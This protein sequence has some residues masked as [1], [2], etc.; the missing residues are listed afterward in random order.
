MTIGLIPALLDKSKKIGPLKRFRFE[1]VLR[2]YEAPEPS[3]IIYEHLH[4]PLGIRARSVARG[5]GVAVAL[6]VAASAAVVGAA[7]AVGATVGIVL[8]MGC[9]VMLP[10]VMKLVSRVFEV[11]TSRSSEEMSV[12][13]KLVLARWTITGVLILFA[14][15]K[16]NLLEPFNLH[17]IQ[18]VLLADA[19]TNPIVKLCDFP[20]VLQ[21]YVFARRA[22]T[23]ARM[24]S[25]FLGTTV[26]WA[27][28][29]TDMT[30]TVFVALFYMPVFPLSVFYGAFASFFSY[31]VDMYCMFRV[32]HQPAEIDERL[33][34]ANRGH[35]ALALWIHVVF[36]LHLY[37]GW[38][39]D[40]VCPDEEGAVV[41]EW[42]MDDADGDP[43]ADPRLY[44]A[45]A[46][47]KTTALGFIADVRVRPWMPPAQARVVALFRATAIVLSVVLFVTYVNTELLLL[48]LLLTLLILLLLLVP[49]LGYVLLLR[50]PQLA[51]SRRR[52]TTLLRSHYYCHRYYYQVTN[53]PLLSQ[54][55][56][57]LGPLPP[58][59]AVLRLLPP[60]RR[61]QGGGLLGRRR[62]RS[63][64]APGRA[65]ERPVPAPRRRHL[66]ARDG[67]P[68]VD[69]GLG[70]VQPLLRARL[71]RHHGRAPRRLLLARGLLPAGSR[72]RA[73]LPGLR[74]PHAARGL[75][76]DGGRTRRRRRRRRRR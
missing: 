21:R 74:P 72:A 59:G 39:F 38:P 10:V 75:G 47:E 15:G 61:G 20:G 9:N 50:P 41:K 76:G 40:E 62:H 69:R 60:S 19:L 44:R 46:D 6:V 7:Q 70:P 64:R 26:F 66:Q 12:L 33:V 73:G 17:Q 28:R 3:D 13:L 30:K 11:H 23:Q 43:V 37:A 55:L 24:N 63:V 5:L 2:V 18:K 65:Q 14:F 68:L 57:G 45:C 22:R 58:E 8:I 49:Q 1:N 4:V 35:L 42:K 51:R 29:Y 71:A 27:E 36:A 16:D 52:A 31:L 53:S 25:F 34:R 67:P 56:R 32:W 48:L 54:V